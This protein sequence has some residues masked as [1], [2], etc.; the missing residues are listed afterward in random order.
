MAL[1]KHGKYFSQ[2]N[3]AEFDKLHNPGDICP[4]SG[5][6]RCE[7]CGDE[8]AANKNTPLPPQNH[9]QHAPAQGRIRWKLIAAT[10]QQ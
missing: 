3:D 7:S 2:S 4:F 10:Q 5:I 8:I 9:H 1:Y 6:Y